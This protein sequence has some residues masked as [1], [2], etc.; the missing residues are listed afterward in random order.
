MDDKYTGLGDP[1]ESLLKLTADYCIQGHLFAYGNRR[2]TE[3]KVA[4]KQAGRK[5]VVEW[6]E[7]VP[8]REIDGADQYIVTLEQWQAKLKEWGFA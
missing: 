4:G 8:P 3:G 7:S 1:S 2:F 5:E 6:I